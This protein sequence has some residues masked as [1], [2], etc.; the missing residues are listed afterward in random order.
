LRCIAVDHGR[1]DSDNKILWNDSAGFLESFDDS[2]FTSRKPMPNL[3]RLSRDF[4]N[5]FQMIGR[6]QIARVVPTVPPA[7]NRAVA[8]L[9]SDFMN[10]D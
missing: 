3:W 9:A 7:L 4:A 8:A 1:T 6:L 2:Q 10:M 5:L